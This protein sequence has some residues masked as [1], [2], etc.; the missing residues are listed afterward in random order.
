MPHPDYTLAEIKASFSHYNHTDSTINTVLDK[1]DVNADGIIDSFDSSDSFTYN[2]TYEQVSKL[3][4]LP[5]FLTPSEVIYTPESK[6]F[7]VCPFESFN[8]MNI[9][10]SDWQG[11][12][13]QIAIDLFYSLCLFLSDDKVNDSQN[14]ATFCNPSSDT[15]VKSLNVANGLNSPEQKIENSDTSDFI[16]IPKMISYDD[17]EEAFL[18]YIDAFYEGVINS[19]LSEDEKNKILNDLDYILQDPS[20]HAL[21]F[22]SD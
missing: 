3:L 16:G 9:D 11:D 1:I 4:N 17:N 20:G 15:K 22:G 6:F 21:E 7:G 14:G 5:Y 12:E 19:N 18:Q 10:S 13:P 8:E 2:T